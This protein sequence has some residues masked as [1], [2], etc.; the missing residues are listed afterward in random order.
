[1]ASKTSQ[2]ADRPPDADGDL[3][4]VSH[5]ALAARIAARKAEIGSPELPRN[6][7]KRR[8]P[9]KKALLKAIEAAG[10]KW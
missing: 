8:T 4:R 7:G 10:G 3:R 5:R 2:T 6:A 9:S 1:M